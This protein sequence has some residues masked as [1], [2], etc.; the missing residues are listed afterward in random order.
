MYFRK[1]PITFYTQDN[2]A[3]LQAIQSIFVRNVVN[4]NI[5]NNLSVLDEYDI[6]DGDTPEI[7]SYKIYGN[8]N[9][10]WIIMHLN[11]IFDARFEWP[12]SQNNLVN[13]VSSKYNDTDGIHHYEN[14]T[15]RYINGNLIINASS[16]ANFEVGNVV[17]NQTNDGVGVV[18][19]KV[20][21]SNIFVTVSSGGFKSS[22]VIARSDNASSNA[23]ITSTSTISGTAVTNLIFEERQNEINRRIKILKPEFVQ[24]IVNE[25]EQKISELV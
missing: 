20:D 9:Y 7:V 21:S 12:L 15:G 11:E 22:D 14:S 16:F 25:Y 1:H 4:Q 24:L 8:P 18:T 23:T 19:T 3:S 2:G 5:K 13:Y 10:H 6:V 17:V